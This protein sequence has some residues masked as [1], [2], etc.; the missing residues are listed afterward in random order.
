MAEQTR[1]H[2]AYSSDGFPK[3]SE[4][5]LHSTMRDFLEEEDREQPSIWNTATI[6][7]IAMFLVAML[8]ILHL[9]GLEIIPGLSGAF[10]PLAV[11]GA[12]LVGFIGFGF[13]VGD[14]KRIKKINRRQKEERK[15]YFEKEFP[16]QEYD[17]DDNI[18]LEKELFGHSSQKKKKKKKKRS[19]RPRAFD[20]YA[21]RQSKKLYKS[22][23]KKKIAGV[24]GGLSDYFGIS[25]TVIRILFVIIFFAGSGTT[26]LVYIAGSCIGQRTA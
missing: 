1:Q 8:Y 18:N 19:T 14:R 4:A 25:A 11:I 7:G 12:V 9:I 5:K 16:S 21:M 22:R 20:D 24:C 26:L 2:S 6:A 13:F 3:F 15:N 23:T 10:V 17:S